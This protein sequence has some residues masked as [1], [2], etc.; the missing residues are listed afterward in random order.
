MATRKKPL[1]E[2][3]R[4]ATTGANASPNDGARER[5]DAT[6]IRL[7]AAIDGAKSAIMMV[8]RELVITYANKATFA[9]IKGYEAEFKQVYP[10]FDPATLV[11]TCID[12]FHKRPEHQRKML[13]DPSNL[14]RT[15][16]IR[17]GRLTFSINVTATVDPGGTY[18]GNTLEWYDVTEQRA[19][20]N[21]VSR[22]QAAVDGATTPMMMIDRNLVITYVI[23]KYFF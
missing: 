16:D 15:V 18:L 5:T 6:A 17:V 10:G 7:A 2:N 1:H 14:P 8:D 20:Q 21:D 23:I 19:R 11:G 22:L 13:A 3:A 9:L 12:I 4:A